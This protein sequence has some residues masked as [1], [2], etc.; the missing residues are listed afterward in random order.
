[1]TSSLKEVSSSLQ[2]DTG[3][4][5]RHDTATLAAITLST[6]MEHHEENGLL[7]EDKEQVETNI[8]LILGKQDEVPHS[9][10]D[11]SG[12]CFSATPEP[13]TP[14]MMSPEPEEATEME[15]KETVENGNVVDGE[16]T[17]T[18]T[19]TVA[20]SSNSNSQES[21]ENSPSFA[22]K[23]KT[24]TP[25]DKEPE[26]SL[27]ANGE[28]RGRSTSSTQVLIN[29]TDEHVTLS[30]NLNNYD[31][32]NTLSDE[33][34]HTELPQLSGSEKSPSPASPPKSPITIKE[35][36]TGTSPTTNGDTT[37]NGSPT[38]N[39]EL[40]PPTNQRRRSELLW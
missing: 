26:D 7:A 12:S 16:M 11:D 13:V 27:Q 33:E 29:D 38:T 2:D 8:D 5:S 25:E 9:S 39:G 30:V 20:C 36:R 18:T 28:T 34:S 10:E 15:T 37:A 17:I 1:M 40:V 21:A 35:D 4:L 23:E 31:S 24:P 22:R 14:N 19:V 3:I 32:D 6:S